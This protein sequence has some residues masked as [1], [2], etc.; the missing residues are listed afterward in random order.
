[1][2]DPE[3]IDVEQIKA[4]VEHFFANPVNEFLGKFVSVVVGSALSVPFFL[5]VFWLLTLPLRAVAAYSKSYKW[6]MRARALGDAVMVFLIVYFIY[7]ELFE[8][9]VVGVRYTPDE[10]A[11]QLIGSLSMAILL[12]APM[13]YLMHSWMGRERFF[14]DRVEP[15]L[16][17]FI[18]FLRSFKDDRRLEKSERKLMKALSELFHPYAIGR[19]NDFMPPQGARRIY[20]GENWKD[21]VIRL[22]GKA[23]IILQR[24]NISE[25]FLWEFDQC[26][27]RG[28]L[29]RVVFWVVDYAEYEQFRQRVKEQ[30]ALDFPKL[31]PPKKKVETLFYLKGDDFC[32]YPLDEKLKYELFAKQYLTDR[33]E[34]VEAHREY[35]YGREQSAWS[36]LRQRKPD[37]RLPM[38]ISR[39]DWKA[40]LFPQFFV[41]CHSVK[42]RWSLYL[43][44]TLAL[45]LLMTLSPLGLLYL[46]LMYFMGKN[47]RT[48]AWLSNRWESY[49]L[50]EKVYQRSNRLTLVL[51][52]LFW[53]TQLATWVFWVLIKLLNLTFV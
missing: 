53:L 10:F 6:A 44:S 20:V 16:D 37:P 7:N 3:N 30:Y 8:D 4:A 11:V 31:S 26:V 19:P 39:W 41:V 13:Y 32:V 45:L 5:L 9:V 12:L 14:S 25:N 1:M 51:G 29:D 49:A 52:I 21:V 50:F 38:G 46:P 40:C 47:G 33:P 35:L 34:L 27:T 48:L 28:Y 42:K 43:L 23:P 22:Q 24:I 15:Y 2:I 36:I 17:Y 18:L